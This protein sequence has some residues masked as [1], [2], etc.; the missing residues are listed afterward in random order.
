MTNEL[1]NEL[2][3]QN[4]NNNECIN[5][6]SSSLLSESVPEAETPTPA[7]PGSPVNDVAN[8]QPNSPDRSEV[9][10]Y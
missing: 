5:L 7:I 6:P 10:N 4:N 2:N 3:I 8:I 1:D 9:L